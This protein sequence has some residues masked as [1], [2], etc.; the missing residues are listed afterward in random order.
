MTWDST[1]N[2]SITR[3]R[4]KISTPEVVYQHLEE[5]GQYVTANRWRWNSDEALE[6]DL[7]ER[8]DLLINLAL[9]KN[10]ASEQ[11]IKQLYHFTPDDG[12]T[13]DYRKAVRLACLANRNA[14]LSGFEID[15]F[16]AGGLDV[17]EIRRIAAAGDHDE[18]SA[19]FGNPA[20][21]A[22]IPKLLERFGPFSDLDDRRW[23]LLIRYVSGNPDLNLDE[24]SIDGP[25]FI[26]WDMN[27]AALHVL[28]TAPVSRMSIDILSELLINLDP[29]GARSLESQE[30]WRSL[31]ER[32]T[33]GA[34]K[35]QE[36]EENGYYTGRPSSEELRGLIAAVY[37]RISEGKKLV[38]IGAP[39]ADDIM[40]RCAFYGGGRLTPDQIQVAHAKDQRLFVLAAIFNNQILLDAKCRQEL[41][42]YISA[43]LQ[44]V[45]AKRCSQ[46][47]ARYKWFSAAPITEELREET[48]SAPT[49]EASATG[50]LSERI[51]GLE[52]KVV[53]ASKQIWWA[54]FILGI[55]LLWKR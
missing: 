38:A 43:E 4:L 39:D 52:S 9:A 22:L 27:K 48:T 51:A 32:W 26:H 8:N 29:S 46:L 40:M 21:R 10:A 33:V 7:L 37:H 6:K 36:T 15:D 28:R 12:I 50:Q 53:A 35:G 2:R 34:A 44:H 3:E 41:E 14:P 11:V 18:L 17:S 31:L 55:L 16:R 47:K 42:S 54:V 45:Y 49:F 19:M 5:Y 25:D 23:L 1:A 13:E 30:D 24:S 20:R